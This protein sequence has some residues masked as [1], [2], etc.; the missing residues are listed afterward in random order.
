MF[1]IIFLETY[2]SKPAN[3]VPKQVCDGMICRLGTG[4][5][6][7]KNRICDKKVDCLDAEDEVD[8]PNTTTLP[9]QSTVS[10]ESP[11]Q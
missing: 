7:D 11:T 1:F 8:C 3:E 9:F 10:T 5:C 4:V 6:L 2:S